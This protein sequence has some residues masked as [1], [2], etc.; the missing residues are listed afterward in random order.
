MLK[1][2]LVKPS[3]SRLLPADQDV[4]LSL[5][6]LEPHLPACCRASAIMI[7]D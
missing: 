2:S 4:E 5:S 1:L 3:V 7:M 6:S